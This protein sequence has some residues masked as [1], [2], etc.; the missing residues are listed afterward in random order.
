[1][2]KI[3]NREGNRSKYPITFQE[4]NERGF[5]NNDIEIAFW[6]FHKKGTVQA[7]TMN[8]IKEVV[9]LLG[10]LLDAS[11]EYQKIFEYLDFY[12]EEIM[13]KNFKNKI[14]VN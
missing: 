4:I 11:P 5:D 12:R 6:A 7:G 13:N 9:V 1:M 2:Q 14:K 3:I 8:G 10:Q